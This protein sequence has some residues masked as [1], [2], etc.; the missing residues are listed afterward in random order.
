MRFLI[1]KDNKVFN[2]SY[3]E[4]KEEAERLNPDATCLENEDVN[5]QP[6]Y[7]LEEGEFLPPL[8]IPYKPSKCT[9]RQ[10]RQALSRLGLR[11]AVEAAVEAS[12][13]DTKDWWEFS[14]TFERNRPQVLMMAIALG[15][16]SK[17]LDDLW[18]LASSL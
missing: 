2:L 14:T 8:A 5:I 7:L 6:G 4:S 18:L 16:T 17:D 10:I 12:D 3:F 15:K 1:I 13:Q 11:E 9:P